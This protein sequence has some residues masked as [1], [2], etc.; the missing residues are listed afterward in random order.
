M[1]AYKRKDPRRDLDWL[2][3]IVTTDGTIVGECRTMNVSANGAK[4]SVPE[5]M[6]VPDEFVLLLSKKT[7]VRRNCKIAWRSEKEIGV[8][9]ISA[10]A[11]AALV[12]TDA[13]N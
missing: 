2:G 6:V 1:S 5:L 8:R 4:I 11:Q 12:K 10:R 7:R 9:F 13:L 3:L